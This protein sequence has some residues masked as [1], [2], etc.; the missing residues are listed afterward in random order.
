L[1][2]TMG[3]ALMV[4]FFVFMSAKVTTNLGKSYSQTKD[5][6]TAMI[7]LESIAPVIKA[8][9]DMASVTGSCDAGYN[10]VPISALANANLSG[11]G[12]GG[13]GG[14]G[15][16]PEPFVCLPSNSSNL[17]VDHPFEQGQQICLNID[18][19]AG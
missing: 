5:Q 3:M 19:S 8:G 9:F 10:Q 14:G 12:G 6:L 7:V 11:E 17:C 4:S 2:I 13:G 15:S 16:P 1:L 18:G